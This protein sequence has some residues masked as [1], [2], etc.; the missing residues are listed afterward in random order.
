MISRN[1]AFKV[2][3]VYV[4]QSDKDAWCASSCLYVD[5]REIRKFYDCIRTC[6]AGVV[7]CVMTETQ[8][9]FRIEVY[10]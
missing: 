8:D 6:T 10:Q 7:D 4:Y 9:G 2:C 5:P 3:H 1:R